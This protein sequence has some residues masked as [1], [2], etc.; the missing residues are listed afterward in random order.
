MPPAVL[1]GNCF[2]L[3]HEDFTH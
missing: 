2:A 1:R 3:R